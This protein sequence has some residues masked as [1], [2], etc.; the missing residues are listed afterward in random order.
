MTDI[1]KALTAMLIA[2]MGIFGLAVTFCGGYFTVTSLASGGDGYA[3]MVLVVSIPS[4]VLGV[5][6]VWGTYRI[7]LA[8]SKAQPARAGEPNDS[9]QSNN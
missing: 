1:F 3:G 4:I 6:M 8:R 2:L 5:L 9:D 7:V